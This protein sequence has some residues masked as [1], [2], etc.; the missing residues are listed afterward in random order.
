MQIYV[1]KAYR[2]KEI[3]QEKENKKHSNKKER[4]KT[5]SIHRRHD[6]TSGKP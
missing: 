1:I 2:A 4:S 3:R 5:I 6:I